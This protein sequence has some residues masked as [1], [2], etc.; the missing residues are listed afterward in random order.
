MNRMALAILMGTLLGAGASTPRGTRAECP[1]RDLAQGSEESVSLARGTALHVELD[2]PVD[3]KK[4]K[5][6]DA[7]NAHVTEAVK[8]NGQTLIPKSTKLVGH[9]TQASARAKGDAGSALAIVF[10]KAVLKKGQE[11]PL[12]V[13]IQAMAAAPRFT[14]DPGPDPA[15]INTLGAAAEGSPMK[16][17][18]TSPAEPASRTASGAEKSTNTGNGAGAGLDSAG[19]LT[20]NSHGVL[21]LEGLHLSTDAT[22]ATEGSLVT[23]SGKSVHLDSGIRILLVSE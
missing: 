20:S 19:Q 6:G 17:S 7:V 9:V 5:T 21:G 23:S 1:G 14:P 16:P 11:I 2:T 22:S 18:H 15:S 13:V 8:A 10:D 4:A 3:S 12:R